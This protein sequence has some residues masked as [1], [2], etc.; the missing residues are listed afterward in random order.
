FLALRIEWC[1]ARAHA[2]RWSE[3]C[4]LIEEEMH[5]VI[6]FHAYQARWWLDKIEQNP[7][8]SEEH[9]EGLIAYAMRQAELRTS[10]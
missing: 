6:A 2:N 1:K 5:R 7:V 9:Q 4:Q 3:E 8:A 10:L